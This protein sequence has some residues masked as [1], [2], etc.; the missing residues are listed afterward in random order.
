MLFDAKTESFLP[1]PLYHGTSTLFQQSIAKLGLGGF[2]PVK[3]WKLIE[4]KE[5]ILT[6]PEPNN[7]YQPI[8]WFCSYFPDDNPADI[9]HQLFRLG[10][11]GYRQES[12]GYTFSYELDKLPEI[13]KETRF[14]FHP[15]FEKLPT[16][17]LSFEDENPWK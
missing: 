11:L 16:G 17:E 3:Q 14:A 1:V 12:T 15:I 8:K 4:A 6:T 9:V 5:R 13:D 10:V 7:F 2:D